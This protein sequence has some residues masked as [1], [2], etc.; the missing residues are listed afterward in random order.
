MRFKFATSTAHVLGKPL[1][2]AEAATWLNEHFQSSLGDV[3]LALDKYFIGGV[4]HIFYHGTNY[5]PKNDPWPGWLFYAAVHF[6]P[7]NPFWKDLPTLN[8]YVARCQSFLQAGKPDNDVLMYFPIYDRFAEPGRDLLHHFDGMEGFDNT[9]FKNSASWMLE[10]GYAF[11]LFSDKQLQLVGN[12]GAG[13]LSGG[14]AY[15]TILVAETKYLPLETLQKLVTLAQNGATILVHRSLPGDVPGYS[16]LANRQAAFKKLIGTIILQHSQRRA[17]GYYRERAF[18]DG[19][20]HAAITGCRQSAT[21]N[22]G[23]T[24]TSMYTPGNTRGQIL[25]HYEYR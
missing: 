25:F 7:N 16:N 3:K 18:C 1:A 23:C 24:R 22:N 21:G 14:N 19:R 4:N 10:H 5:S 12:K 15:K 8:Q 2:S 6:H 13:L 9:D 11:D 17:T 20:R